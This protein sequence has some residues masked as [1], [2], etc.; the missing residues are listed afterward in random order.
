MSGIIIIGAWNTGTNLIWNILS[1]SKCININT[2][3]EVII[4]PQHYKLWKH[5]PKIQ[6]IR[7]LISTNPNIII[8]IMYRNIL[9]WISSMLKSPYEVKFN[10]LNSIATIQTK[11]NSNMHFKNILE[12]Y[13]IYYSNYKKIIHEYDNV[14][15]LNYDR[16]I[17][18][19]HNAFDYI[20]SK[21]M[22]HNLLLKSYDN[23]ISTLDKPSKNHGKSV[24]NYLEAKNKKYSNQN[25]IKNMI[26][27]QYPMLK[28]SLNIAKQISEYY[29]NEY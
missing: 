13:I 9:N 10:N 4:H 25:R 24:S 18:D 20:N 17:D 29:E 7:Q 16:I 27:Q 23:F 6:D 21:L 5:E 26:F 22:K 11:N 14:L 8:I 15:F 28:S 19:N 3:E 1:N 12:L 2:D